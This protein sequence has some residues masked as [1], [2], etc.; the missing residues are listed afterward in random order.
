LLKLIVQIF[1]TNK[2]KKMETSFDTTKLPAYIAVENSGTAVVED[3][4]EMWKTMFACD[5][6]KP[7][8]GVLIDNRS[9]E[10]T[11]THEAPP[12]RVANM[13]ADRR[14]T[15]GAARIAI[16]MPLTANDAYMRE[17]EAMANARLLDVHLQYFYSDV[18]ALN[19]LYS[20]SLPG[21]H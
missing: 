2:I 7:G 9:I 11:Y 20:A 16:V 17:F 15:L 1:P 19:W 3:M 21:H 4:L 5:L 8:T 6:W 18:S 10:P 12:E 14:S 13:L